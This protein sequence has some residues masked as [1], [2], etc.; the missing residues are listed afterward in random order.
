ME[1]PIVPPPNGNFIHYSLVNQ[2]VNEKVIQELM[3][4]SSPGNV[5]L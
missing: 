1:G 3:N 2:K 4:Q 5:L